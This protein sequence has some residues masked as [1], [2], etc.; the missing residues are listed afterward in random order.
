MRL[1]QVP[2]CDARHKARGMCATHYAVWWR[3]G[4]APLVLPDARYRPESRELT[5]PWGAGSS[6]RQEAP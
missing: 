1:C 6:I 2:G 4:R 3:G 5:L